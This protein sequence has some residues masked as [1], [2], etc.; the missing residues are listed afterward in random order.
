MPGKPMISGILGSIAVAVGIIG[1][2]QNWAEYQIAH[3]FVDGV[4]GIDIL[5]APLDHGN[6]GWGSV[7]VLIGL[8][9][10]VPTAAYCFMKE[11]ETARVIFFLTFFAALLGVMAAIDEIGNM[12]YSHGT[13]VVV[14]MG[15]WMEMGA[16]LLLFIAILCPDGIRR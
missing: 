12:P 3:V 2:M 8:I 16:S 1:F 5:R 11:G 10:A 14:G 7:L 9:G 13:G 6:A 4:I 15:L